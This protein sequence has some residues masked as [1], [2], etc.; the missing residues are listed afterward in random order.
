MARAMRV[1]YPGAL[2]HITSR[3]NERRP[4][5]RN[6]GDRE[7]FLEVLGEAC[8]RYGWIVTAYVLMG[9]HFHFVIET[10]RPN[11]SLGM[12]WLNGKYAASFNR[13]H[14]RYGHLYGERFHAF[15]IDKENY[16]R[17]V[18][19]YTVLN[20][21]RA[22]MVESPEAYE[23]SSYRAMAGLAPAPV[24][25]SLD[26]IQPY[27][28][29]PED[30]QKTF[31]QYVQEK[32]GSTERLWDKVVRKIFLGAES[33]VDSLRKVIHS[34]LRSDDHPRVQREVG[35]PK[36]AKIVHAVAGAFGMRREEIRNGRGGLARM[37][38][39]WLGWYEGLHRLRAI[40]AALRLQSCGRITDLV[41][42]C[43]A[44]LKDLPELRELAERAF[45]ILDQPAKA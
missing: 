35:R 41:Q 39:A 42:Q 9:N 16:L 15:L 27:F 28:G 31:V 30:W 24:W 5:F 12:Q 19:R 17:E 10:P 33:W 44:A 22:K 3:G 8:R 13:R 11:L 18:L 38:T 7:I 21:V 14:K 32:I 25:L 20:P 2:Y 34:K 23:W 45:T 29:E 40:A 37:L 1:E 26:N 6:R 43:E 36:M 4:I